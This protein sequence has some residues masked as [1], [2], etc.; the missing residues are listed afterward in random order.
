MDS[1]RV[2][3]GAGD[4]HY[5]GGVGSLLDVQADAPSTS[6]GVSQKISYLSDIHF[7][8]FASSS[9]VLTSQ[10]F[11]FEILFASF[12]NFYRQLLGMISSLGTPGGPS[13]VLIL[14]IDF[15]FGHLGGPAMFSRLHIWYINFLN[16]V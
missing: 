15:Y 7:T 9:S 11:T 16:H 1:V 6:V 10:C 5:D 3:F 8:S 4:M 12:N 13:G 2:T 14:V